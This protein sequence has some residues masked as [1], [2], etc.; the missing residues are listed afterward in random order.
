MCSNGLCFWRSTHAHAQLQNMTSDL[1]STMPCVL[2]A[3]LISEFDGLMWHLCVSPVCT[4]NIS[5]DDSPD[6]HLFPKHCAIVQELGGFSHEI[7]EL[8]ALYNPC[9]FQTVGC[10]G[11]YLFFLQA[12]LHHVLA[13]TVPK[14]KDCLEAFNFVNTHNRSLYYIISYIISESL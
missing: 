14:I 4:C 6:V 1:L 12:E 2:I 10:L 8:C 11:N 13:S 7:N 3:W 5:D 9:G